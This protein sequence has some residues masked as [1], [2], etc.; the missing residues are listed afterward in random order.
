MDKTNNLLEFEKT[1]VEIENRIRDL[2]NASATHGMDLSAQINELREQY[3]REAVRI[4]SSLSPWERVRVARHKDRPTTSDYIGLMITDFTELHGDR[5][6]R[7]DA[8]IVT[9]FGRIDDERIMLV[10][11]R[12]GRNTRERT[13]CNWG[14]AHAEGFRKALLK[15]RIAERFRLPIVTLI[16]TMGAYPGVG[17]EERGVAQAIADNIL[18]MSEMRVPIVSV[19]IGEGGSGGALGIGMADRLCILE[20][21]YYSVISPEGC[22]AILWKSADKKA[23]AANALK[24]TANNLLKMGIADEIVPEPIGGAHRDH[25]Q[26]TATLKSVILRNVRE[27]KE[28]PVDDLLTQRYDKYRKMG[29]FGKASQ[30][31]QE[32][33]S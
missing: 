30:E 5:G 3:K 27:L 11:H 32:S 7:D 22:A 2:E 12:K 18:A 13:Q 24:L 25:K 26:M 8:A 33:K 4:Y 31:V 28:I 21:A 29:V 23:E 19:V 16:D 10:G 17:A 6:F 1:L 15:M 9:G 20:H 14:C